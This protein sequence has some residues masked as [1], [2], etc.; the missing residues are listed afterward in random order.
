[1]KQML[2]EIRE[3]LDL[4]QLGL[5]NAARENLGRVFEELKLQVED[6]I[7]W[8]SYGRVRNDPAAEL[9]VIANVTQSA[10]QKLS[11]IVAV[12]LEYRMRR[13]NMLKVVDRLE[14]LARA[15]PAPQKSSRQKLLSATDSTGRSRI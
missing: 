3:E 12:I 10:E 5:R 13:R 1:M 11:Q 15:L 9:E 4:E 6:A 14:T 2:Q 8:G 7:S